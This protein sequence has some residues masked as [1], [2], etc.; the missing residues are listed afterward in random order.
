MVRVSNFAVLNMNGGLR[1][2]V[3]YEII[4]DETRVII[5][6]SVTETIAVFEEDV[7]VV[8]AISTIKNF[9]KTKLQNQ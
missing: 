4:D 7:D 1:I 2:N 5:N 9:I 6:P 3:T 8:N